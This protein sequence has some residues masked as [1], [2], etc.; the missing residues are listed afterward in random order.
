MQYPRGGSVS[1]STGRELV[2]G[3]TMGDNGIPPHGE[4]YDP[5][6]DTWSPMPRSPLRARYAPIAV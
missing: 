5:M 2:R 1:G 4:T 6:S 3:G